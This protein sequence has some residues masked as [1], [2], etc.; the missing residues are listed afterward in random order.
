MVA[1]PGSIQNLPKD[2]DK[3]LMDWIGK[4]LDMPR[5]TISGHLTKMAAL[6]FSLKADLSRGYTI[7]QVAKKPLPASILEKQMQ[8]LNM[9]QCSL[10]ITS[11]FGKLQ[12][13]KIDLVLAASAFK[14]NS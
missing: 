6:P 4:R 9:S 11:F 7:S 2:F 13:H 1:D 3:C 14:V 5:Q 10:V 8:L 12:Q